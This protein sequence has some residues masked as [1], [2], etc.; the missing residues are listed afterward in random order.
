[1]PREK[2]YVGVVGDLQRL[3][4]AMDANQEELPQMEPF[5]QKLTGLVAQA[6]E[7]LQQQAALKASKQ[8]SSK[9]LRQLLEAGQRLATVTRTAVKEHYGSREEKVVEFGLQPFRGRK[10]KASTAKPKP[11][12]LPPPVVPEA[13]ASS[14]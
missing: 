3:L 13:P 12:P 1:M 14:N 4:G 8:E 2:K 5:R 11:A 10:A 7:I 6:L 9:R